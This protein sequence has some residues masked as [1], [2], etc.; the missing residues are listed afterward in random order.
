M[1]LLCSLILL[2]VWAWELWGLACCFGVGMREASF[3]TEKERADRDMES[4]GLSYQLASICKY[5]FSRFP[6]QDWCGF[7]RNEYIPWPFQNNQEENTVTNF[8]HFPS[9]GINFLS[10]PFT[11]RNVL[12]VFQGGTERSSSMAWCRCA[13]LAGVWWKL[14]LN[15]D[16]TLSSFQTQRQSVSL[17]IGDVLVELWDP[18]KSHGFWGVKSCR[19]VGIAWWFDTLKLALGWALAKDVCRSW[20]REGSQPSLLNASIVQ[21]RQRTVGNLLE[22]SSHQLAHSHRNILFML[23]ETWTKPVSLPQESP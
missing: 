9:H 13:R 5:L 3:G 22:R 2:A 1:S 11:V 20:R 10:S 7:V 6:T 23:G 16:V 15:K 14:E 19:A 21:G 18:H 4:I 12:F 17:P 8:W